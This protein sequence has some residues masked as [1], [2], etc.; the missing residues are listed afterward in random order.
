VPI[1]QTD[2]VPRIDIVTSISPFILPASPA[3]RPL[4]T[5]NVRTGRI[6]D[7]GDSSFSVA[8]RARK[9]RLRHST[10]LRSV[11]D[12]ERGLEELSD[13]MTPFS[14][15]IRYGREASR[16]AAGV[17]E[18]QATLIVQRLPRVQPT[19]TMLVRKSLNDLYAP[20]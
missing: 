12:R 7:Y 13:S 2:R 14:S 10:S 18:K 1:S 15:L 20:T 16:S 4:I 9:S 3:K 19:R 5:I 11:V 17:V 6:A 8:F